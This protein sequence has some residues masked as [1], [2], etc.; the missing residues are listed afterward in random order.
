M[1]TTEKAFKKALGKAEDIGLYYNALDM[2]K[3]HVSL[4]ILTAVL[5]ANVA[6]AQPQSTEHRFEIVG[7]DGSAV[8]TGHL[9][10]PAGYSGV[11]PEYN[12]IRVKEAGGETTVPWSKLKTVNITDTGAHVMAVE[13][14]FSDGNTKPRTVP[15]VGGYLRGK[16]DL[17]EY[18]ASLDDL[19]SIAPISGR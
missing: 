16:T 14:I 8:V 13:L 9:E 1:Q 3:A 7:K 15:L 5:L 6:A 2:R 12:G 17:G 19:K 11:F 10:Y 4:W 18:K